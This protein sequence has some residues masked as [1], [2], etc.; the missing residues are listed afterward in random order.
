MDNSV[1]HFKGANWVTLS[2]S[3][4]PDELR[5]IAEEVE[6]KFKEFKETQDGKN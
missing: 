3:F 2:G 4:T 5:E 6:T 1:Q